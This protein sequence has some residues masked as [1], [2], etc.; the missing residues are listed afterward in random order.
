[1]TDRADPSP[2]PTPMARTRG[3]PRT[4][5]DALEGSRTARRVRDVTPT[6]LTEGR[7]AVAASRR[8]A[9]TPHRAVYTVIVHVCRVDVGAYRGLR[10][11]CGAPSGRCEAARDAHNA[12][13][14]SCK[15]PH[16][17]DRAIVGPDN[18]P[19][20]SCSVAGRSDNVA[21]A[22][23]HAP[24]GAVHAPIG[25]VHASPDAFRA[26]IGAVGGPCGGDHAACGAVHPPVGVERAPHGTG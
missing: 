2:A 21:S 18:A 14:A 6:R 26:P 1:M 16:G 25:A 12:P 24:I 10:R 7:F 22:S 17:A 5:A 13:D 4:A 23:V 8:A 9:S 20:A 11:A 15:A 3:V 19:V